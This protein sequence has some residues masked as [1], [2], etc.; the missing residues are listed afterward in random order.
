VS[1]TF[2]ASL[3]GLLWTT[4]LEQKGIKIKQRTFAFWNLLP[5]IVMTGVGLAV[6]SA[7]FAVLYQ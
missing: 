1:F 5:I 3:A 4:I 7:E 6:V 2:S